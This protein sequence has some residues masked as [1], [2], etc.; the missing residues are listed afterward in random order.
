MTHTDRSTATQSTGW[1]LARSR[2]SSPARLLELRVGGFGRR[3]FLTMAG[4]GSA[5]TAICI[6]I[7]ALDP[8]LFFG[9]PW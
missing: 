2:G 6:T 1:A 3:E 5:A 4:I 9:S 8:A 7:A